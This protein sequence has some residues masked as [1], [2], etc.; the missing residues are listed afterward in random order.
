[1]GRRIL[2]ARGSA[3]ASSEA[4]KLFVQPLLQHLPLQAEIRT[5]GEV[6]GGVGDGQGV[7]TLVLAL[8][9]GFPKAPACIKRFSECFWTLP[10]QMQSDFQVIKLRSTRK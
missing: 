9:E 10:T 2:W 3:E 4:Q 7:A 6:G 5:R 1:M 8:P